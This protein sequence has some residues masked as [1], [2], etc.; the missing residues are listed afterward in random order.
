MRSFMSRKYS[1]LEAYTPGE[2]PQDM[3]YVKLNTNESPFPPSDKVLEAVAEEAGKLFLG[4][5][6]KRG[7]ISCA[8]CHDPKGAGNAY[9][10]FPRIGGQHAEYIGLQLKMFRAAGREDDVSKDQK[11][12]NDAAKAGEKGMMQVVAAKLSDLDIKI[13]SQ[14]VSAVH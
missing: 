11:R 5:D 14:F 13:L 10:A 8:G 7:V 4:G 12:V 2:Q 3:K 1:E 6:K 9:A